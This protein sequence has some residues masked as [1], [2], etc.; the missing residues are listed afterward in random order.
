MN[1]KQIL[2]VAPRPVP[3]PFVRTKPVQQPPKPRKE[4]PDNLVYHAQL[5][6]VQEELSPG[7]IEDTRYTGGGTRNPE[8]GQADRDMIFEHRLDEERYRTLKP[9]WVSNMSAADTAQ[10]FRGQ[11][12]F[13]PRTLDNYWR[14][15]NMVQQILTP[16]PEETVGG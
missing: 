13:S 15:F 4:T 12:G 1:W 8:I 7:V 9:Y 10:L 16:S 5:A 2:G 6:F 11:R 3:N 14:V